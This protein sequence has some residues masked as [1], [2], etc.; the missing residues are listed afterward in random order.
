MNVLAVRSKFFILVALSR[1]LLR[2]ELPRVSPSQANKKSSYF[3]CAKILQVGGPVRSQQSSTKISIREGI[4]RELKK[5]TTA[6]VKKTSR[7]E[8]FNEQNNRCTR[9]L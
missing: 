6:T 7:N 8:T 4:N 3:T 2:E 5:T 1:V 9:V